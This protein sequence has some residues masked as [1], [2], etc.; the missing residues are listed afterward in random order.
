MLFEDQ[1]NQDPK[2][3]WQQYLEIQAADQRLQ[4]KR[5]EYSDEMQRILQ[6]IIRLQN[7]TIRSQQKTIEELSER[8]PEN[9]PGGP[10]LIPHNLN[11]QTDTGIADQDHSQRS[12]KWVTWLY[13][14]ITGGFPSK[15]LSYEQVKAIAAAVSA[16]PGTSAEAIIMKYKGHFS[17]NE[18]AKAL[19]CTVKEVRNRIISG[20]KKMQLP[21]CKMSIV[22]GYNTKRALDKIDREDAERKDIQITPWVMA[23]FE[24]PFDP[25]Y[26]MQKP[27]SRAEKPNR[28][29]LPWDEEYSESGNSLN[30]TIESDGKPE[31]QGEEQEDESGDVIELLLSTRA[32][33]CLRRNGFRTIGR[34]LKIDNIYELHR[35]RNLGAKTFE[36]IV[37]ALKNNGY[38]HLDNGKPLP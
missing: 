18:I 38:T 28:E 34:L 31:G 23:A 8:V 37:Q 30:D 32:I 6:T 1:T 5:R 16:L 3:L 25:S 33:N 10:E 12:P 14:D 20:I 35:I 4:K 26:K 7:E 19:Y 29:I 15:P 24:L 22:Y 2:E 17:L 9:N 13:R 11:E 27:V 36:E 21:D